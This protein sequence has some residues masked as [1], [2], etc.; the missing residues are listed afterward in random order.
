MRSHLQ[1]LDKGKSEAEGQ[2]QLRHQSL[3]FR[4]SSKIHVPLTK[5]VKLP[6]IP[7]H[8]TPQ[9]TSRTDKN[10]SLI[11]FTKLPNH[12]QLEKLMLEQTLILPDFSL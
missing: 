7:P 4:L 2:E 9:L 11:T 6:S 8:I 12:T 1:D 10:K 5:L 3:E